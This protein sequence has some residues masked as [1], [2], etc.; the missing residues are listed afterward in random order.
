MFVA[1][2][3]FRVA[4]DRSED[5]ERAWRERESFLEGFA[6]FVDFHLLRSGAEADG[7]I[8]Y[9]SHTVWSDE[10]A[11]RAWMESDAFRKAHAQGKLTGIL[12][13][14]PRFVGWTSVDLGR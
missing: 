2:N 9:A 4:A 10:T 3:H 14:P 1:M 5:F 6:G 12:I 11:F 8:P 7:S 13:G